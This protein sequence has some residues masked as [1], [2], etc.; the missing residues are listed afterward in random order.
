MSDKS[1]SPAPPPTTIIIRES[2]VVL[3]LRG[4]VVSGDGFLLFLRVNRYA[5]RTLL[6]AYRVSHDYTPTYSTPS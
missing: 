5:R 6:L 3:V 1:R 2:R 4:F